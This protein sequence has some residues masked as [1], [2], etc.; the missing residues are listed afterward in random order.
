MCIYDV[1]VWLVFWSHIL[2]AVS[3]QLKSKYVKLFD[4]YHEMKK[5]LQQ[6]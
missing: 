6:I 2:N 3:L 4:E 1:N 5:F